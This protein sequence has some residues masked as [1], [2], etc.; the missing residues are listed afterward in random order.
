MGSGTHVVTTQTA[1][2]Q[3]MSNG[4]AAD[5]WTHIVTCGL[6]H[7]HTPTPTRTNIHAQACM[8]TRHENE[9]AIRSYHSVGPTHGGGQLSSFV[10]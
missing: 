1:D 8:H 7:T 9:E 10:V 2:C 4:L 6:T 3:Q 5:M